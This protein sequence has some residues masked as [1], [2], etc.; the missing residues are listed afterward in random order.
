VTVPIIGTL[1]FATAGAYNGRTGEAARW[2]VEQS[3][4]SPVVWG[5]Y[6][7]GN[8]GDW[9]ALAAAIHDCSQGSAHAVAVLSPDPDLTTR[10]FPQAQAVLYRLRRPSWL[11]RRIRAL[12]RHL[13][14]LVPGDRWRFRYSLDEQMSDRA[15]GRAE[16]VEALGR[17]DR[18]YLAGGGYLTDLFDLERAVMPLLAARQLGLAVETAPLG[19]GPFRSRAGEAL[20]AEALRGA[21]VTVRDAGSA[22]FC[23]RHAIPADQRPDD[24]FRVRELYPTLAATRAR[25]EGQPLTVGVCAH[26]QHG[27][28]APTRVQA[29]W[30]DFLRG[31]HREMPQASLRGFCFHTDCAADYRTTCEAFERAGLEARR[32]EPPRPDPQE[33]VE[34]LL[35]CDAIATTRFHAAVVAGAFG[36]PC[37]AV[38][39]GAYYRAKMESVREAVPR[40]TRVVDPNLDATDGAQEALHGLLSLWR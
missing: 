40:T 30:V 27:S 33:A 5:G 24:G 8:T 28:E 14:P 16:W 19:I 23:R 3:G 36:L 29:W 12:A 1:V 39:S 4:L 37:V 26:R 10:L 32:V 17:A 7:R 11:S 38:A 25:A 9:L 21:R 22:A 2:R 6:G 34:R 13:G 15:G 35:A 20:V 31:L 18:L